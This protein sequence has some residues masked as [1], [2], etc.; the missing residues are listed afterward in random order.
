M[1]CLVKPWVGW[2]P[3]PPRIPGYREFGE[4][5][6]AGGKCLAELCLRM[7]PSGDFFGVWGVGHCL[8]TAQ[9]FGGLCPWGSHGDPPQ[10][11]L[12]LLGWDLPRKGGS[13]GFFSPKP[14]APGGRDGSLLPSS[15]APVPPRTLL[16]PSLPAAGRVCSRSDPGS[17]WMQGRGKLSFMEQSLTW[18]CPAQPALGA[19]GPSHP[20]PTLI[21]N[22]LGE[23]SSW[24]SEEGA[25]MS[26]EVLETEIFFPPE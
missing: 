2:A 22:L 19:C 18:V 16:C 26:R 25:G 3:A 6:S 7:E 20:H 24:D 4:L 9:G 5:K 14:R 10:L 15:I 13:G 11:P 23:I 12:S 8:V 21:L 1:R 17:P